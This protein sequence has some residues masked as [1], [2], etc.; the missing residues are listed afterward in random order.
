MSY[1]IKERVFRLKRS[2]LIEG[3]EKPEITI[4]S[5]RPVEDELGWVDEGSRIAFYQDSI[6]GV[7][8]DLVEIRI[9]EKE[10]EIRIN[11]EHITSVK[12]N[13]VSKVG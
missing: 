11:E 1:E 6:E 4:M 5:L 12:E 10:I 2:D 13:V 9:H 7:S 3:E 8:Q